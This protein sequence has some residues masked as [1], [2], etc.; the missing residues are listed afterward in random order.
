[1]ACVHVLCFCS[2]MLAAKMRV[3]GYT[4][5]GLH[6]RQSFLG[7]EGRH[8]DGKSQ[9]KGNVDVRKQGKGVEGIEM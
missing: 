2:R 1:M 3:R 4:A 5:Q 7:F 6:E 8:V 9:D